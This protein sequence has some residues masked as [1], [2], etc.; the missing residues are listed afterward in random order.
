MFP[1]GV[2]L[3]FEDY[4]QYD[5]LIWYR[6][7]VLTLRVI[8]TVNLLSNKIG[9]TPRLFSSATLLKQSNSKNGKVFWFGTVIYSA[10]LYTL[11]EIIKS[12]N[13]VNHTIVCECSNTYVVDYLAR[14]LFSRKKPIFRN[15]LG[16]SS[17]K[18]IRI[19]ESSARYE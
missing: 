8:F 1:N 3:Q 2:D 5:W 17:R 14:A 10:R 11:A 6:N 16:N 12:Q 19:R 15:F 4:Q 7:N 9:K 13:C 18:A